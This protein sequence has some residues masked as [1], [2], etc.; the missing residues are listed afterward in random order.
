MNVDSTIMHN[1]DSEDDDNAIF[2]TSDAMAMQLYMQNNNNNR[3]V[4]TI[5]G[6]KDNIQLPKKRPAVV[7]TA[8][9]SS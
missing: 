4:Q 7:S 8:N 9:A 6:R 5:D 2:Q 3:N 1:D